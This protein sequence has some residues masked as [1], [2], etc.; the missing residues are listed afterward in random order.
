MHQIRGGSFQ[1]NG[2]NLDHS[3]RIYTHEVKPNVSNHVYLES[4]Y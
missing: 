3:R 4:F 1:D 2:Y